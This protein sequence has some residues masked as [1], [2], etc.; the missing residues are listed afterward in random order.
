MKEK[1]KKKKN[2]RKRNEKKKKKSWRNYFVVGKATQRLENPIG[3]V[4]LYSRQF[5]LAGIDWANSSLHPAIPQFPLDNLPT[6]PPTTLGS[7]S[8]IWPTGLWNTRYS[9]FQERKL[10]L[11]IHTF[12]NQWHWRMNCFE[13][14]VE[15]VFGF[16]ERYIR[17]NIRV[18]KREITLSN[19]ALNSL[20]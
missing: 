7:F 16:Y 14:C 8:P 3:S 20:N 4:C 9:P 2:D 11:T 1:E 13:Q 6:L 18:N 12:P 15:R 17:E 10:S 19:T 5:G